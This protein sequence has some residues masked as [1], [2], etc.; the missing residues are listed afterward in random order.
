MIPIVQIM[1]KCLDKRD[2]E[3]IFDLACAAFKLLSYAH[4]DKSYIRRL[5]L[6]T[7]VSR[8]YKKLC[9]PTAPVTEYVF[10]KDLQ[11]QIKDL[12]EARKMYFWT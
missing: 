4:K 10:G 6:K 2:A 9:T 3:E 1:N 12:N 8:P 5:L 7:A 11:K